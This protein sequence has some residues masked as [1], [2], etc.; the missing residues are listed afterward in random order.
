MHFVFHFQAEIITNIQVPGIKEAKTAAKAILSKGCEVAV[1]TLGEN[2]AVVIS[3]GEDQAVH[4]PTPKVQAMDTTVRS[5]SI[6]LYRHFQLRDWCILC[7]SQTDI[8]FFLFRNMIKLN[9]SKDFF[10]N[11]DFAT[12]KVWWHI[13]YPL[14]R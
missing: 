9:Q 3:K 11:L 6:Y 4:I 8:F 14:V 5:I 10:I 12:K 13:S 2:G 1:V 7:Y